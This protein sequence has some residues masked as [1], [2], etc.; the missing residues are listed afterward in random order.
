[1]QAVWDDY[2]Y[3]FVHIKKTDSAGE[4]GDFNGKAKV[5]ETVDKALPILL[6]NEPAALVIT[7]DHSTPSRMRTHSWHPVPLLLWAPSTQRSDGQSLFGETYC[8]KGGL[9]TFPSTE[10]MPLLMAHSG[11]LEKFGA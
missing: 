7:G 4:D 5:I 3:F 6:E 10:I 9:G 11:R 1:V 8:A 2:D